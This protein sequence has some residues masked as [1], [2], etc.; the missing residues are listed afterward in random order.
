MGLFRKKPIEVE[1]IVFSGD[2][3]KECFL[4]V[5]ED[6]IDHSL[7][8]P[9]IKTSEGLKIVDVGDYIVKESFNEE[10][11]LYPCKPDIFE[12]TYEKID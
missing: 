11:R 5:G 9:N 8:Y 12:K 2:N 3:G 1:A 7:N 10:K 4:F 6:N